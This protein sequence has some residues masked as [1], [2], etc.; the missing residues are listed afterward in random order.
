MRR[1]HPSSV[2]GVTTK[3]D[4]R[5]LVRRRLSAPPA[6]HGLGAGAEAVGAGGAELP[7]DGGGPGSQ[8]LSRPPSASSAPSTQAHGAAPGRRTT[9]PP[10]PPTDGSTRPRTISLRPHPRCSRVH[11]TSGTPRGTRSYLVC[12]EQQERAGHEGWW[13]APAARE[14]R[15]LMPPPFRA[16]GS[17]RR[18]TGPQDN[19]RDLAVGAAG[20]RS[21]VK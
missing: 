3:I 16:S 7:V 14:T 10:A 15:G 2:W 13:C 17:A 21:M 5:G 20:Y 12:S 8:P 11:P 9:R 4:H 18:L 1:C 19:A 6:A